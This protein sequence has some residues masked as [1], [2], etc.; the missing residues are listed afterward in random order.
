MQNTTYTFTPIRDAS[1]KV[2]PGGLGQITNDQT[3]E[4]TFR[5]MLIN[6]ARVRLSAQVSVAR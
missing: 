6:E 3:G 2:L 5:S 4:V 1:G